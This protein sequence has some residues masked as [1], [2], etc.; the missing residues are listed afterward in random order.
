VVDKSKCK[1]SVTEIAQFALGDLGYPML[2]F[3]QLNSFAER[4]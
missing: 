3:F 2:S 4:A 1:G